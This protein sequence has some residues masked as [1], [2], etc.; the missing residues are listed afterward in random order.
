MQRDREEHIWHAIIWPILWPMLLIQATLI[1]LC[2]L[3]GL[4]VWWMSPSQ[5]SWSTTLWL[6]L[7]LLLG[8][9]MNMCAFLMLVK[10][11]ARQK[12]SHFMQEL[13]E[14]ERNSESLRF[15]A[16]QLLPDKTFSSPAIS[17][18]PARPLKRL[19]RV[20]EKLS[21]LEHYIRT[22][23]QLNP[24]PDHSKEGQE[25]ALLDDLHHQQ[26][27]LKHLMAGRDRA[28]EESRL[29][30]GYL[31]LLQRET[32]DLN[33]HL[34]RILESDECRHCRQQIVDTRERLADARAL[35]ANLVYQSVNDDAA[36]T[37]MAPNPALRVL[38]VDDG[39]VNLM[40]ARQMLE[41]Q[42]L[43]VEGVS[44]GEQALERQQSIQFDLVF[45]DIFMPTLDGLETTRRWRAFEQASGKHRSILIAL[46][47]NADNA[48]ITECKE[49]GMD[50]LLTKPY[51]PEKLLGMISKWLPNTEGK[52]STS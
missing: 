23:Q 6:S 7:A 11:R 14:L 47:A 10:T 5:V 42:G 33:N 19:A 17:Q 32:D 8:S 49:A 24:A 22:A 13:A 35:L 3:V 12:D 37:N 36:P 34:G 46:T 31:S 1:V 9:S 38:V 51:Q 39:P 15:A 29:K 52:A 44:S 45:M 21:G 26:Q 27:Q 20:N 41:A 25:Q 43:H 30:T 18:T 4:A 48:G 2:L 50:D 40:L 16:I 28:R